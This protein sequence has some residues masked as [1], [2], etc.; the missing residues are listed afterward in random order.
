LEEAMA[1][2]RILVVD[3][4]EVA[5]KSLCRVLSKHGHQ[6]VTAKNAATAIRHLERSCFDLVITDVVMEGLDGLELLSAVK[7]RWPDIEVI[8]VTGFAS[9]PSAINATRLGAYHYLEKP[10]RPGEVDHLVDRALE[11]VLL[12]RRVLDL[13]AQ[14]GKGSQ[15]PRLLGDSAEIKSLVRLIKQ[16]APTDSTVLLTGESGTGKE[17]VASSIHHYS[18]RSDRRFLAINCGAFAE[19]LL[20]NELFGHERGAFTGATRPRPGLLE[21]ADGGTLLL[22]EVGDMPLSMQVKLLRAIDEQEIIRVGGTT[23]HPI[24]VRI[25]AATNQ[26]LKKAVAASLFRHDLYY[27][28]NVISIVIPPLRDRAADI[29]LLAQFLLSRAAQKAHK[30]VTG[31]SDEAIDALRR[32]TFPG[33]VRE[34]ENVVERGVALTHGTTIG[35]DDLPPD[36]RELDVFSFDQPDTSVRTLR[37]IERDYIQWVLDRTGRNKTRAARLLGIDRSSLWRHLKHHEI[38][39]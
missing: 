6:A 10:L 25:I 12:R 29:P 20:A 1:K 18:R 27:R 14:V 35:Y 11:T 30:E 2:A 37:E 24:D 8:L 21:S 38:E 32:Y 16:I 17:L 28:L 33:N 9:I 3:D 22:D 23:A 4:D 13:E 31:F 19:E 7:H 15:E 39:D 5:L 34:L 26:D 36:L